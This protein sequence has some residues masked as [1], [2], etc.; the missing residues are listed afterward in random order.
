MRSLVGLASLAAWLLTGTPAEASSLVLTDGQI[1]KGTDVKR[2]GDSYLVTMAD[3]YKVTYP[4]ALVKEIKLEDDAPVVQAPHGFDFSGARTLAGP[5]RFA[6]PVAE[7]S[8]LVLTDGQVIKGT[9]V[10]REGDSYLVTMAD[11]NKVAFPSALVKEVKL[12]DAPVV[13]APHGFDLSGPRTLAGYGDH[14]S[15]DP[16]DQLS[17]FGGPTRWPES[18]VDTTWVPT[19]SYDPNADVMAFTRSTWAKSA[20]DTTWAPMSAYDPNKDVM[21][22]TRSTW[23]PSVVDTTWKPTDSWGFKPITFGGS[24]PD[25][26]VPYAPVPYTASV[27]SAPTAASSPAGPAP[28]SCAEKLF[29]KDHDRPVT[30][31]DN[32]SSSMDLKSLNGAP[33]AALGLPLYEAS[34]KVAGASR[35]AIFTIAGDECRLVG[36]DTDALIGL[37]LSSDH[38]MAQDVA[39]LNAAMATRGGARVAPGF[40]PIAYALAFVSL[41]D[42]KVS[43]SSA[44]TLKLIAKPEDVPSIAARSQGP[45]A[46]SKTKRRREERNATHAFVSP[47]VSAAKEGDV[48]T[49]LTWSSA[50]GTVY[51]N[52]V[53]LARGGVVSSKRDIVASHIGVHEE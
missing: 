48:I 51:R 45:C 49:F 12:E 13:V 37:N 25:T 17:V 22:F 20:V 7:A 2:E 24:T 32:R 6:A 42:P 5:G 14:A 34:G 31:K 28:W 8:S 26:P 43:G 39:S 40:D 4:V 52:T 44:A 19:N 53:V 3:G 23:S 46:I 9:D 38:A 29:A 36:G 35:K 27:A 33:Y 47:K 21:A 1:I 11:G 15:Q 30:D 41:T 18:A 10:K 50:G 16:K